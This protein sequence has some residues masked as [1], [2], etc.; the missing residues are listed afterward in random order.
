[1]NRTL[2]LLI[3]IATVVL[4]ALLYY[5]FRVDAVSGSDSSAPAESAAEVERDGVEL[6][7]AEVQADARR[8][9]AVAGRSTDPVPVAVD[10]AVPDPE[11]SVE[12]GDLGAKT[13]LKLRVVDSEGFPV[14]AARAIVI[15]TGF[16]GTSMSYRGEEPEAVT[17]GQGRAELPVWTWSD[18]D[19]RTASVMLQIEHPD[20]IPYLEHLFPLTEDEQEAVLTRGS[21]LI[22]SGWIGDSTRRITDIK[23]ELDSSSNL[24]AGNW[25][26]LPDGRP[27]TRRLEPGPHLLRI[28][29]VAADGQRSFSEVHEFDAE[30]ATEL[31]LHLEL[32]AAERF[33]GEIDSAVPRPIEGGVAMLFLV[34]GAD[35]PAGGTL[36]A[37]YQVD[38]ESDGSFVFEG[39][40]RG[41]GQWLAM[42]PGW[43][44]KQ[45]RFE[46][47][48]E[49]G[50]V[51]ATV[52][53]AELEAAAWDALGERAFSL[54]RI[55]VPQSVT[56]AV[57]EMEQG[58]TLEAVVTGPDG[59]PLTDARLLAW[60]NYRIRG[61]GSS[62]VPGSDWMAQADETGRIVL[63]GLPPES[64]LFFTVASPGYRLPLGD[65]HRN[66]KASVRS[67][68][69]TRVDLQLE[70]GDQ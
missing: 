23:T 16:S 67:G 18:R 69:V 56:P 57:I 64:N 43:Y 10:V 24:S 52:D 70:L 51:S 40:P 45:T 6:A 9:A 15:G 27:V 65:G 44:S 17:D 42:V 60:P 13:G 21:S 41:T 59:Q 35:A 25:E 33:V 3:L 22:V 68:E 63:E 12:V 49:A 32:L 61:W 30:D 54:P 36:G 7:G 2:S 31:V 20:F 4:G 58:G 53:D 38:V 26:R 11:P 5:L 19:N 47:L 29:H 8:E 66:T 1:M 48:A 37:S 55:S 14:E 39:L 28:A 34:A 50:G 62:T 46:S